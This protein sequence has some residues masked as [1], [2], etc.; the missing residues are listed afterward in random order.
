MPARNRP[1]CS[2]TAPCEVNA[3]PTPATRAALPISRTIAGAVSGTATGALLVRNSGW[4]S[5]H[6]GDRAPDR[7]QEIPP[8]RQPTVVGPDALQEEVPPA[9]LQHAV[10]PAQGR[11]LVGNGAQDERPDHGIRRLVPEGQAVRHGSVHPDR[12]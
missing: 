8:T 4:R 2:Q 5:G 3:G 9:R 12:D 11:V 6:G 1:T 10:R 7:L